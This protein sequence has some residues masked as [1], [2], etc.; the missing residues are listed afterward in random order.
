MPYELISKKGNKLG[1]VKIVHTEAN[2]L[3]HGHKLKKSERKVLVTEVYKEHTEE[4]ASE[5]FVEGTFLRV[6]AIMLKRLAYKKKNSKKKKGRGQKIGL[7]PKKWSKSKSK[8]KRNSGKRYVSRSGKVVPEKVYTFLDCNCKNKDCKDLTEET[9]RSAHRNFWAMGDLNDQNAHLLTLISS[10]DKKIAKIPKTGVRSKPKSKIRSYTISNIDVCKEI[11]KSTFNISNGRL[12]R[13]LKQHD[14]NPSVIAKDK[15]GMKENGGIDDK[16]ME[17]LIKV[18]KKLPKY[19]SHY[20]REKGTDNTVFLEPDCQWDNVY[21]I[22]DEELPLKTKLPSKTWFYK[23]VN[24][25]FPHVKTHTPSTDKCNTCSILKLSGNIKELEEHQIRAEGFQEQMKKD[26]KNKHCITFDLQQVQA[27]PYLKVNKAF[28]NRKTWLYDLGLHCN[29]QAY[30]FLWTENTASRGSREITS[31]LK[32]FQEVYNG[33]EPINT[34]YAWSDSCGGQNRNFNVT[35]F[36]MRVISEYQIDNVIHRF[37]IKG[38]SFLPNDRDFGDVEKAKKKKDA[39]YTVKQ[40]AEMMRKSK[41]KRPIV[42]QLKKDN[43]KDFTK[44]GNFKNLSKPVDSNGNKFSWLD[45]HEFKYE[46]GLFGFRFRYNLEDEYRTCLLGPKPTPRQPK[47][48]PKFVNPP[49]MYPNGRKL[50]A[51]K[52]MDLM[53]LLQFVP[54]AYQSFYTDIIEAHKEEVQ[55]YKAQRSAKNKKAREKQKKSGPSRPKNA[56]LESSSDSDAEGEDSDE[57]DVE[58][59]F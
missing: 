12:G 59:L 41:K 6:E 33:D 10:K 42:I 50:A 5:E 32:Y 34:L 30:L 37:P 35:C 8:L 1:V 20:S 7:S 13:L 17:I 40:Y 46:A 21:N 45:I 24:T 49:L 26:L 56:R 57:E 25:L 15:R 28:Y 27:L 47:P 36:W 18:I 29:G 55:K 54:P 44:P 52:V 16:V 48:V 23:R 58:E 4:A 43:F 2:D 9:R 39:L 22:L 14:S 19:I 53:D 11:F 51:P 3:V 38:H 31:C